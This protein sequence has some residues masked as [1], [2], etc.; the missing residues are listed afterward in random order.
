M[1]SWLHAANSSLDAPKIVVPSWVYTF[2]PL[3][4]ELTC[5]GHELCSRRE[6]SGRL[7][8]HLALNPRVFV[9]VMRRKDESLGV[10]LVCVSAGC[11][12]YIPALYSAYTVMYS[13]ALF[14]CSQPVELELR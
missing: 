4:Q 3:R 11:S 12:L 5:K 9:L 14:H 13:A 2:A 10:S 1:F 6:P 7:Q 8:Q